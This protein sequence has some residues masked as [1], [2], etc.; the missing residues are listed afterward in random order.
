MLNIFFGGHIEGTAHAFRKELGLEG[1]IMTSLELFLHAGDI[2]VPMSVRSRIKVYDAYFDGYF[3]CVSEE[4]RRFKK[5]LK[6]EN[7][8]CIWFSKKDA[9]EYLGMLAV[10][11]YLSGKGKTIYLCDYTDIFELLQFREHYAITDDDEIIQ[12]ELVIDKLPKKTMPSMAEYQQYMQELKELK[13]VNAEL[14]IIKDGRIINL[15]EDYIDDKIFRL[16]GDKEVPVHKIVGTI[17][18]EDLPRMLAFTCYR[19]HQLL[20]SGKL[21]LVKQGVVQQGIYGW[22]KEFFKSVVKI[23]DLSN[24]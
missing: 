10:L 4:I 13:A 8:V 2:S 20:D 19:L 18:S 5:Y 7:S 6:K 23:G 9:D 21:I 16:I 14:R 11:E 24:G 3:G 15:P 22:A 12:N 1:E 17:L